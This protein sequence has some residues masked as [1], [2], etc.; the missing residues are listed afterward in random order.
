MRGA[1]EGNTIMMAPGY[2]QGMGFLRNVAESG[3]LQP[4]YGHDLNL[5]LAKG[6]I[7][8]QTN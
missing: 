2:E 1:R 8:G 6:N 7:D 3:P 4:V 5:K